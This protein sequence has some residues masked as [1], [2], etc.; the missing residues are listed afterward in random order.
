MNTNNLHKG[1]THYMCVDIVRERNSLREALAEKDKAIERL[2]AALT[3]HETAEC[4]IDDKDG[5]Y[6]RFVFGHGMAARSAF[7]KLNQPLQAALKE[8]EL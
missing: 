3:S 4:G 2:K 6:V 1:E 5:Y 8:R 7:D